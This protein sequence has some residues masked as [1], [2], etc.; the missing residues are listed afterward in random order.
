MVELDARV[1]QLEYRADKTD[2]RM[3]KMDENHNR[4]WE[5]LDMHRDVQ[6]ETKTKVEEVG[7]DVNTLNTQMVKLVDSQNMFIQTIND[8]I[9]KQSLTSTSKW[10]QFF[11][12][13][14]WLLIGA[15]IS[16]IFI[17]LR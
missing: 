14:F 11:S 9:A 2:E 3:N 7:K 16:L 5:R 10:E 12:K 1:G 15:V 13:G 4:I 17:K 6:I 8:K